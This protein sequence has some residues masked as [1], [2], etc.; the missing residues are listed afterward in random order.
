MKGR[1]PEFKSMI[2][3]TRKKQ[4]FNQ[5][6]MKKQEFEKNEEMLRNLQ[7]ILKHFNI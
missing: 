4:T 5:N 3:K 2:W 6:G 1:K 7:D